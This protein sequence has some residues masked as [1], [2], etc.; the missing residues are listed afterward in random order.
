MRK[1]CLYLVTILLSFTLF[2]DSISEC[3]DVKLDLLKSSGTDAN[4]ALA[5][6]ISGVPPV[7]GIKSSDGW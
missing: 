4:S 3:G 1:P 7:D 2:F 6:P 5:D